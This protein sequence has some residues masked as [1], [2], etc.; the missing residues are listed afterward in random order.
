MLLILDGVAEMVW[1][2][3]ALLLP[4]HP[5]IKTP[6]TV[7]SLLAE[8]GLALWLLIRGVRVV[9]PAAEHRSR[10]PEGPT[11]CT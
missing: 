11:P 6:G 7:V 8:V 4:D 1:F 5:E 10:H 9:D 2:L 3:Q